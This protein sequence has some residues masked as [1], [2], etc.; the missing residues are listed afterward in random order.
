MPRRAPATALCALLLAAAPLACGGGGEAGEQPREG[1]SSESG[2]N[3]EAQRT[4]A[5]AT[6]DR[7][8]S[9]PPPAGE[10]PSAPLE[11]GGPASAERFQARAGE[12]CL[13]AL[14]GQSL[15]PTPRSPSALRRHAQVMLPAAAS[16]LEALSATE[17]PP[18]LRGPL[19]ET[20]TQLE[21][22]LSLYQAAL[23]GPGSRGLLGAITA[24]EGALRAGASESGLPT[25][26]LPTG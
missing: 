13:T 21:A 15:P 22:T 6:G 7:A 8:P 1:S 9:T 2:G 23:T 18:S 14:R 5:D 11:P 24:A 12:R 10:Q 25:C 3:V 16:T 4:A 19:A 17:P 20:G 26:G